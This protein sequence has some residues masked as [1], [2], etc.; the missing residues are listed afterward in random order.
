MV[1]FAQPWFLLGATLLAV[2]VILHLMN[3]EVPRRLVF[4]SVRFLSRA[5]M[6]RE[7]R[8]R[9]RDLLLLAVRLGALAAAVLACARPVWHATPDPGASGQA[10][11]GRTVVLL[12]VSASMAA[13]G[14]IEAARRRLEEA[15]AQLPEDTRP[16]LVLSADRVLA[17]WP[18]GTPAA[19]WRRALEGAAASHVAGHHEAALVEASRLLG[20]GGDGRLLIAGDMQIGDW[21]SCRSLVPPGTEI[22]LL[23]TG[24]PAADNVAITRVEATGLG[25][26][27]RGV[28]V[29][30][31]SF[32]DEARERTLTV[33]VGGDTQSR[34]ITVPPLQTRRVALSLAG[35]AEEAGVASLDADGYRLDDTFH[36]WAGGV[37][38]V[39]VAAVIPEPEADGE[40]SSEFFFLKRALEGTLPGMDVSF[41]LQAVP[42]DALFALDLDAVPF[43]VVLGA[44]EGLDPAGLDKLKEFC[45]GGG[46]ALCTPGRLPAH[47]VH[48]LRTKDLF[49][50]RFLGLAGQNRRRGESFGVGWVNPDGVFGDVFAQAEQTDL[51]L[52][53]IRSYLRCELPPETVV[54][55]RTLD[56][57]PLLA[58]Q[59]VGRGRLFFCALGL[60]TAWSDLPL[61]ASFLP[62]V[63]E[64]AASTVPVGHGRLRVDCGQAVPEPRTLLSSRRQESRQEAP[65]TQQPGVWVRDGIPIEVNVSRRESSPER[66]NA[67]DLMRRLQGTAEPPP[68]VAGSVTA[69]TTTPLWP[70]AALAAACFVLVEMLA[71]ALLDHREL[72]ARRPAA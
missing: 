43:T 3:R 31:R 36:F 33:R 28:I 48:A 37:P 22:R 1:T 45:A 47:M 2:P 14:A 26:G 71:M 44:L 60:D 5:Q 46:T 24:A 50:G 68:D 19:E 15:L 25:D 38:P 69:T 40:P 18:P 66:I 42:A 39:D 58:E 17:S 64:L 65:D 54:H 51:F 41:R 29:E 10:P 23:D 67:Y 63:R 27:R 13:R 62:M 8:R 32:S 21:Q 12:D 34:R 11:D 9:L 49:R 4:P 20:G 35:T 6:P 55:L 7:G 61:T 30:V 53:P 59:A 72:A 57:D 70:A 52:F 56:G 16:G